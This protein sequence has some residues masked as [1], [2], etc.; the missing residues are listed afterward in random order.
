M[1]ADLEL[2]IRGL[3]RHP[4]PCTHEQVLQ[5]GD[6][7]SLDTLYHCLKCGRKA[8]VSAVDIALARTTRQQPQL[9]WA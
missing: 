4:N 6:S 8:R 7:R 9:V 2:W 3:W 1:T 5:Q